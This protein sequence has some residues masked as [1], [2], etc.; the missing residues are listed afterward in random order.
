[1][2]AAPGIHPRLVVV[3]R[4]WF[5]RACMNLLPHGLPPGGIEYGYAQYISPAA[6]RSSTWF[7]NPIELRK[8]SSARPM[9]P[10]ARC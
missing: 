8:P 9:G 6:L 1:M 7:R 4:G 5:L 3:I 10:H 2:T